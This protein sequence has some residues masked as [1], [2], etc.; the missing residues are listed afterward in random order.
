LKGGVIYQIDSNPG[1]ATTISGFQVNTGPGVAFFLN[2]N[3]SLDF[4]VNYKYV[5]LEE[6]IVDKRL[7]FN[8]GFQ[9]YLEGE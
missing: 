4:L 8:F 7:I 2:D 6:I 3:V 5:R 9:I 1:G